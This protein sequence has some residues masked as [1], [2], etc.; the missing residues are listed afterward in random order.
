[1]RRAVALAAALVVADADAAR[2]AERVPFNDDWRFER[3]DPPEAG[4]ALDYAALRPWVLPT[5]NEL[6]SA[7][8]VPKPRRPEGEPGG[9]V[10]YARPEFDDSRW[11]RLDLPHD[12][13]IEG[14]FRQE[15]PGDTGKLPWAG[16][17]WYR[18]RFRLPSEDEG[19]RIHLDVDG[20]MAYSAVWL[21][22]RFVGGW[23]YGYTSFRLDLTP[24]ARF[25]AE[26]VLAVRLDNPPDSS[27]W[28]PGSGLYRNVWLVKT[29]PLRVAHW[30]VFVR[31]PRVS[32][33]SALVEVNVVLEN[34]TEEKA[35]L[36]L[37]TRVY[38]LD[39]AGARRGA[40]AAVS[41]IERFEIDPARARQASRGN[42]LE[43]AAPRLWDL[44]TPHRYLAVTA[45]SHRERVVDEQETPF[46]LR[47]I[48]FDPEQGF[49][50]NGRRVAIRGVC[51]HH[52]LGALGTALNARALER[53]VE[54]LQEMGAN[55]IRTSHNPPAPELLEICDRRG[56]L[57]MD[58][59][60]DCW[61][62]G[63][64]WPAGM[65]E[66]DPRVVYLDYA[67][68]FDDWHEQDLRALV[69][70]DR[71]HPSVVMWS[72]GNEVIEQWFSDGW[73]LAARLAGIVREEDR[74]RPVTA[75]FNNERAGYFG[76]E[77][78]VDLIGFNYKGFEYGPFHARHPE[79]PVY[80]AETAST[81]S[82]RGE[83]FFPVSDDKLEGRAD[84]HVSSYDLYA[85]RW[86][87]PPDQ[88]FRW[89]DES[90]FALGEFVWTGFDYLG[91][92]TP[93]GSDAA[94]LLDFSDA[95]QRARMAKELEALGRIRVPSR[96]SYF[97]ILDLAGFKKDRFFLYQ[98]RWRPELRMAH[99][100]PH[101]TWPERAGLVTPVHVYSSADEAELFLNGR[102]LGRRRR[103]PLEYRFR[104]NDVTFQP[105]ELK[106]VTWNGGRPWAEAVRRT[107]GRAARLAL[108]ADRATIRA[109][110]RDLAFV[111]VRVTDRGGELAP[112]ASNLV[113]FT[114]AGP[115]EIVAVD[116]GDPTSHEPFQA[117]QRRAFGG[118]AL[119]VV[120]SRAG[121]PGAMRLEA[122]ADGLAP[123]TLT[124]RS[125]GGDSLAR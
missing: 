47:S 112:R 10:H 26:N 89:L 30:G 111:T 29:G 33:E 69:R 67:R 7:G 120:R 65:D 94:N 49:L 8:V 38:E 108:E 57:V 117:R 82:S 121:Q 62:R 12:W 99:I 41:E 114:L 77:S 14:P 92:P 68:V 115:G 61:R 122:R 81:V 87:N 18:K 48:R 43:L 3:G 73:K 53:Q 5:G 25:G 103:G 83:Y 22:G 123:A 17:G 90:L 11:R 124:L 52:D 9:D 80:G 118:L 79:L 110:G 23:P 4:R 1:V 39:E 66:N 125:A 35:A 45:L 34:L 51:N 88:E 97:G 86:S 13:G 2:C 21:N 101:W 71:N 54:L 98:A 50:L 75:G 109:D 116:N 93:Y 85:P 63:K 91:E 104:W 19:R 59:A 6:L 58:E 72:I 70:R 15:L 60:F 105:G 46:G 28:Y 56:M 24:Y 42:R 84:F 20:A 27:R 100:L 113:R 64:R 76:F 44:A 107:A 16:V 119:V 102:S 31:T 96:S 36:E 32:A 78:V 95:A 37:T 74:T 55:A 40:P 106:V